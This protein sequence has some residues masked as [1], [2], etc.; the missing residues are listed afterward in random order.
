MTSLNPQTDICPFSEP[1]SARS[2]QGTFAIVALI[3]LFAEL[4]VFVYVVIKLFW[5]NHG[6]KIP[7]IFKICLLVYHLCF[8][9]WLIGVNYGYQYAAFTINDIYDLRYDTLCYLNHTIL[10]TPFTAVYS[11]MT[12]FWLLRL[13]YVFARSIYSLNH[14]LY[15]FILIW[16]L[17]ACV[18]MLILSFLVLGITVVEKN[19]NSIFC[20]FQIHVH[21]FYPWYDYFVS[22]DITSNE[23]ND[24][25][26]NFYLCEPRQKDVRNIDGNNINVLII[27]NMT[28]IAA[29]IG[30]ITV[31][32]LNSILFFKYVQ[33]YRQ[34]SQSIANASLQ[35]KSTTIIRN[36]SDHNVDDEK[37][38]NQDDKH[39][40]DHRV[41]S[42][43]MQRH[44][45]VNVLLGIASVSTTL[46]SL[47]LYSSSPI[48]SIL[49]YFDGL[50]N[51]ILMICSLDFGEWIVKKCCTCCLQKLM[52]QTVQK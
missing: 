11:S 13:K 21:D 30:I 41:V 5:T 52:T 45:N 46:L 6:K 16:L 44:I 42:L 33:K 20:L 1:N 14:K 29:I 25:L 32:V 8:F 50:L 26:N 31:P 39:M 43:S 47:V 4:I 10:A 15:W 36:H 2:S 3:V 19:K 49:V 34:L 37:T 40:D 12:I 35:I 23:Y 51:G 9:G 48:F 28:S 18:S 38:N 27:A 17:I 22:S 7:A 24:R